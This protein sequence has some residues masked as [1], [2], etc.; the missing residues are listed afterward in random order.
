MIEKLVSPGPLSEAHQ[1]FEDTCNSCHASFDKSAQRALC[2]DCHEDLA[3]DFAASSG[4]HGKSL[5]VRGARCKVCHTEHRG[6]AFDIAPFEE[7]TF[8][9]TLTD[10]PL[11]GKHAAVECTKCHAPEKKFREA[12]TTCLSCHRSDEPHKGRLGGDCASCH[13]ETEWKSIRFDHSKTD[14][15]LLGKHTETECLACH[16]DE[17]YKDLP[18]TCIDCHRKDDTHKGAFGGEC[19]SCHQASTWTE[20]GFDHGARTQFSLTGKHAAIVCADCHTESLT[21][22]KLQ[23]ACFSCHRKDD[24]HKGRTGPACADCHGT[25]TWKASTFDHNANTKFKLR[26]AHKRVACEECHLQPV[27]KALPGMA[28]IDCHRSDD[29]HKGGQGEKCASCHNEISWKENTRFDHDLSRFPLLGAHKDTEC[30][31]CHDSR[32]FKDASVECD[33]CHADDDVHKRALG[34]DCGLCHNPNSWPFWRFEHD[35]QTSFNLTGAHQGL[36]CAACHKTPAGR[37][38]SQSRQCVACHRADDRHRGQFGADCERCHSTKTF[39]DIR[40][41]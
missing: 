38:V 25:T 10:Y 4:F 32:Q 16:K 21:K 3:A 34:G 39:R 20:I 41:P 1:K 6:A 2:L 26:G 33:A 27:K 37:E 22:P 23:T 40:F 11:K 18:S 19:E 13:N 36:S 24:T 30:S 17:T 14:F 7:A 12:Q 35:M 8:D 15:A 5:E 9:H 28:C 31:A 29:P